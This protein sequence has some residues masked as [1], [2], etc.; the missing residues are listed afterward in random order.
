MDRERKDE[1]KPLDLMIKRKYLWDKGKKKS[2]LL[3]KEWWESRGKDYKLFLED[4]LM[5]NN[6]LIWKLLSNYCV[7]GTIP[8]ALC[9]LTQLSFF[10]LYQTYE[11]NTVIL[12]LWIKKA[13]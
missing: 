7:P 1:E 9:V 10:P 8:K 12:I 11:V 6:R 3:K 5:K 4:L 13:K 2:Q